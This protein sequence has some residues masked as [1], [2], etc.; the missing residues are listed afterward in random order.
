M[1]AVIVV[2]TA[3]L[4]STAFGAANNITVSFEV[5]G[6]TADCLEVTN[7]NFELKVYGYDTL[8][9]DVA[10]SLITTQ[11][12]SRSS[13]PFTVNLA[14]PD[15]AYDQIDPP[16][17]AESAARFYLAITWDADS[18]G[19]VCEGDITFDYDLKFPNIDIE[20]SETQTVYLKTVSTPCT[21]VDAVNLQF[22]VEGCTSS[23]CIDIAN[24]DL[25]LTIYG[26]DEWMADVS[27][28]LI[29]TQSCSSDRVPFEVNIS[30]PADTYDR[31]SPPLTNINSARFYVALS[32]DS[33]GNGYADCTG[34]I[35]IDW[36]AKFPSIYVN[37][38]ELQT[39]YVRKITGDV[40]CSANGHFCRFYF[41][42]FL[43][44][45]LYFVHE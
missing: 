34:D 29:T 26:Y 24:P 25:E 27:A 23:D 9:A 33:D 17:S 8:M 16:L 30:I 13:V 37:T 7:P 45:Y 39:L 20:S 2:S 44:L 10:A 6:C 32:W 4:L 38:K 5:D 42:F 1:S 28:S 36:D 22:A 12:F 3:L 43:F 15:N 11:S 35:D 21:V 14:I 40:P 31:I 18:N 41:Y 19:N